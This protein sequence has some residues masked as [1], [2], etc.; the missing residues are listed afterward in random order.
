MRIWMVIP[1]AL[2][3]SLLG[4]GTSGPPPIEPRELPPP[5]DVGTTIAPVELIEP[6]WASMSPEEQKAWLVENGRMV[7]LTGG[8][9]GIA[10]VT[11]HQENG[12]GVPG[13][14]PPLVGQG[15]VMGDCTN[16]GG[17]II[18]GLTGQLVIDGQTFNGVM[19]PQANLSDLEIAAVISYERSA[20]GND[21]GICFPEQ[22]RAARP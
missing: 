2:V 13:A 3:G 9:A 5:P 19:P 21:Y 18:H 22:V 17:Y 12:M 10:C 14:F 4:C 6:D 8:T 1:G 16:H 15:A 7:Y 20:W 11:C